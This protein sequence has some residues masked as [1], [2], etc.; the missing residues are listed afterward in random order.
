MSSLIQSRASLS[1]HYSHHLSNHY[2]GEKS[3]FRKVFQYM[4]TVKHALKPTVPQQSTAAC[5]LA[6]A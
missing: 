5:T 4:F 3:Q 2:P 1:L 6:C